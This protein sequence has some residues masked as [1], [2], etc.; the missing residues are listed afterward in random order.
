MDKVINLKKDMIQHKAK[1]LIKIISENFNVKGDY[2]IAG[3]SLNKKQ[4]S[5]IDIFPVSANGVSADSTYTVSKTKNAITYNKNNDCILQVCNYIHK[6]LESLVNSFDFTHIQVG[7]HVKD[8]G[9]FHEVNEV[10]FTE[11][12]LNSK[13]LEDS[14]F[15][16]SEYPLSSLIRAGKYLKKQEI[17]RGQYIRSVLNILTTIIERGFKNYDDFKDQLDAVDLGLIPEEMD[18]VSH[19]NLMKLFQLLNKGESNGNVR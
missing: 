6:D 13:I 8:N 11:N 3:N 16:N 4:Y 10:Y 14:N 7:V 1:T 17:S 9:S 12:Y 5:D 2:Y 15:I 18:E 19:A